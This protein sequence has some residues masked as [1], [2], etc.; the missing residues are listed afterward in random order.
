V[1]ARTAFATAG[2]MGGQMN[3][4][5][6]GAMFDVVESVRLMSFDGQVHDRATM[7]A[8]LGQIEALDTTLFKETLNHAKRA[9][10]RIYLRQSPYVILTPVCGFLS[11]SWN[12]RGGGEVGRLVVPLYGSRPGLLTSML[13]LLCADFRWDTSRESAG[14]D[15]LTS[16]TLVAAYATIRWD[17]RRIPVPAREKAGIYGKEN[18]R[19]NWR[20]HYG[21]FLSSALE[22]GKK[23]FYKCPEVYEAVLKYIGLPEGVQRLSK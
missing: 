15:L 6:G 3:G 20:R 22:G 13:P 17:Y 5:M 16:D 23:L 7:L 11:F 2:A 1:T 9:A 14:L 4:A 10:Q 21:L 8:E 12:P 18:D 19:A